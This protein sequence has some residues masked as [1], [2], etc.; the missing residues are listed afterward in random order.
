[1]RS[2]APV[3]EAEAEGGEEGEEGEEGGGGGG[4]VCSPLPGIYFFLMFFQELS[5]FVGNAPRIHEVIIFTS[6]ID[7]NK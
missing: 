3:P 1:M 6:V 4:P 2:S 7:F 5:N